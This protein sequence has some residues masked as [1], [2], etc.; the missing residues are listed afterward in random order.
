[1]ISLLLRTQIDNG[2]NI[3]NTQ[4]DIRATQSHTHVLL[5]AL[6]KKASECGFMAT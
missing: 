2:Q 3:Y 5:V 6:P 1:M 4:F